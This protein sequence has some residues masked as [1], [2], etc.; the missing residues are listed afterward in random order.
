MYRQIGIK[1]YVGVSD[2][3]LAEDMDF[4]IG[5]PG[6]FW[7]HRGQGILWTAW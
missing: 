3:I 1:V 7:L 5:D 4:C 6:T 2:F